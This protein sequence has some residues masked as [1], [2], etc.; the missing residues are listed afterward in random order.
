[1]HDADLAS[2]RRQLDSLATER[3]RGALTPGNE[4][5]YRD[6]CSRER[7]LLGI[8]LPRPTGRR[9][10]RS[11][12]SAS[13]GPLADSANGLSPL[14]ESGHQAPVANALRAASTPTAVRVK[15]L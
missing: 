9:S 4:R 15:K 2:V 3:C 13:T 12:M 11:R 6:L 14:P 10:A 8:E 7:H 1:M 5:L